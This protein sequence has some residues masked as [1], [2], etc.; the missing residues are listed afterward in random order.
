MVAPVK[1]YTEFALTC[2]KPEQDEIGSPILASFLPVTP[3][4]F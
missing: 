3:T 2:Q 4:P 1:P